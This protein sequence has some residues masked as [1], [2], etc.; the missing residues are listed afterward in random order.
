M[1]RLVSGHAAGRTALYSF[2]SLLIVVNL[3]GKNIGTPVS[4]A[5][6]LKGWAPS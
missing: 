4:A 5:E 1:T 3:A 6:P 2:I